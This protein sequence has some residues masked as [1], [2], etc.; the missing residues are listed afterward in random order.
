MRKKGFWPL[1]ISGFILFVVFFYASL[2]PVM[3]Q[4]PQRRLPTPTID[5]TKSLEAA[6]EQ[7]RS[8]RGFSDKNLSLKQLGQLLWAA[9]GITGQMHGVPLRAAPSAGALYPID[10]YVVDAEGVFRYLPADHDLKK[11][12]AGD[13]RS[14][15]AKAA[16]GQPWVAQAPVDIVL[17]AVYSRLST[18]YGTRAV[19]YAQIEAGHIAQNIHLQA[20]ALGLGSVPVGAFV[21]EQVKAALSLPEDQEP[22]YIIPVGHVKSQE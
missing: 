15:L 12:H 1:R 5:G 17:C 7:R 20:V 10:V 19:R 2:E 8:E 11:V 6:I 9:Q 18:K 16:L 4:T 3:S 22:L 13:L 21:D 14:V